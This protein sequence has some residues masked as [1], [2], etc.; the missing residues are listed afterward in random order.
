MTHT[1]VPTTPIPRSDQSGLRFAWKV[2]LASAV[3][4]GVVAGVASG[5]LALAALLAAVT[6][7][8]VVLADLMI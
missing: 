3:P 7:A 1:S 8:C 5:S 6:A 4:V 2:A